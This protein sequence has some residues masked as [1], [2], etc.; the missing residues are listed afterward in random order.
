MIRYSPEHFFSHP[1]TDNYA[2]F[3]TN[4]RPSERTFKKLFDSICFPERVEDAATESSAGLVRLPSY[5]NVRDRVYSSPWPVSALVSHLPDLLIEGT[6]DHVMEGLEVFKNGIGISK[7]SYK[8]VKID[9]LIKA[10][11][12]GSLTLNQD[13]IKLVN[14][15][16]VLTGTKFYGVKNNQKGFH[17]LE[18]PIITPPVFINDPLSPLTLIMQS[19]FSDVE[20]LDIGGATYKGTKIVLSSSSINLTREILAEDSAFGT[21]LLIRSGN[22]TGTQGGDL[23]VQ[24]G[25]AVAGTGGNLSFIPGRS[26]VNG[27]LILAYD[28][29]L[30]IPV[31]KVGVG[32]MADAFDYMNVGG[33]IRA[34]TVK[35]TN[36]SHITNMN[37]IAVDGKVLF[38]KT[39]GEIGY[40]TY[41]LARTQLSEDSVWKIEAGQ[42][43]LKDI[44]VPVINM[45]HAEVNVKKITVTGV[46]A[47]GTSNDKVMMQVGSTGEMK[48]VT[49]AALKVILGIP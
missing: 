19:S 42:V 45:E 1:A 17:D 11:V 2:G 20:T 49:I 6:A 48:S 7:L 23:I 18:I 24:A 13:K 5:A 21:N 3:K 25:S 35:L 46:M 44:G 37:D 32:A 43:K 4:N 22:S 31:G 36:P 47:E 9:F 29:F 10:N 40:T 15:S 27:N 14:D 26:T 28:D 16:E 8:G 30:D 12:G 34:T 33:S 41:A 39:N 38:L